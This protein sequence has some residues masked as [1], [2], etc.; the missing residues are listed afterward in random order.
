MNCEWIVEFS[1]DVVNG[2]L[3]DFRWM[4]IFLTKDNIHRTE[5]D[6]PKQG[7]KHGQV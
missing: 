6:E 2:F 7:L 1:M 5:V 4:F 3:I